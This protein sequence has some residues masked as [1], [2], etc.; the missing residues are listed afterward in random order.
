MSGCESLAPTR[1][2]RCRPF[3]LRRGAWQAAISAGLHSRNA[4]ARISNTPSDALRDITG[5]SESSGFQL[6]VTRRDDYRGRSGRAVDP[7]DRQLHERHAEV[8][9]SITPATRLG[10]RSPFLQ[11][12]NGDQQLAGQTVLGH[13]SVSRLQRLAKEHPQAARAGMWT[14]ADKV[15]LVVLLTTPDGH[16]SVTLSAMLTPGYIGLHK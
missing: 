2:Q 4:G 9:G 6:A 13:E 1:G 5:Q 7:I 8:S 3:H 15:K 12:C 14:R 16:Y 10:S 11:L